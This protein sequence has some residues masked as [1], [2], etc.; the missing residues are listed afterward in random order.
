ELMVRERLHRWMS[1][2]PPSRWLVIDPEPELRSILIHEMRQALR[3]PIEECTP[4]EAGQPGRIE[5]GMPVTVPSKAA[6]VRALLPA[7][8]ELT[9]LAVHP[10][11]LELMVHLQRYLP[12]HAGEL[13]GIPAGTYIALHP[14]G[15][16]DLVQMPHDTPILGL[17][18]MGGSWLGPGEGAVVASYPSGKLKLCY[19]AGDQQVQ[20]VPCAHG[21]F[22]ASLGGVDPGLLFDESGKLRACK[23]AKVYGAQRKGE[24]FA[25]SR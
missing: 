8:T 16:P 1:L 3:L 19:L 24:H 9:V 18:C 12:D 6:L 25:Q 4:D 2:T 23:L 14:D 15:T 11:S 22:F 17:I 21:G 7:G 20:G 5:G 13:V 10:V